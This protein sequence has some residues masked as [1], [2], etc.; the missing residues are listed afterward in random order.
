MARLKIDIYNDIE[1]T[2]RRLSMA[3]W[4]SNREDDKISSIIEELRQLKSE[5]E[6]YEEIENNLEL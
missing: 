4:S 1:D 6:N 5:L 2:T 3:I